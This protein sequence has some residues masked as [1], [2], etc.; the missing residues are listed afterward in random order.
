MNHK[1]IPP[2]GELHAL[3]LWPATFGGCRAAAADELITGALDVKARLLLPSMHYSTVRQLVVRVYAGEAFTGSPDDGFR[4]SK[5]KANGVWRES[6][7]AQVI[8]V[9]S[10]LERVLELKDGVRAVCGVGRHAI[11]TTDTDEELHRVWH[12]ARLLQGTGFQQD[13]VRL[14]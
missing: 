11:H 4:F 12:A 10:P 8:V 7:A 1:R 3:V 5:D 9:Q 14:R 6:D 2:S 13:A